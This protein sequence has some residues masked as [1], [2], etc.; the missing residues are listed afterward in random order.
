MPIL[1]SDLTR[2][3]DLLNRAGPLPTL[4]LASAAIVVLAYLARAVENYIRHLHHK[5]Y[6]HFA[7]PR[8]LVA[9]AGYCLVADGFLIGG[10]FEFP[11]P[12]ATIAVSAGLILLITSAVLSVLPL[13]R[14]VRE[15]KNS[16]HEEKS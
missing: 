15:I 16:N 10:V 3:I 11:L 8:F 9:V 6:L 4:A 12:V 5:S 7:S 1:A 14:Q 13:I 2:V